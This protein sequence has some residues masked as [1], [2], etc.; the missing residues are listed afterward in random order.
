MA[1]P[2]EALHNALADKYELQEVLGEGGMGTVYLARDRKHDRPVA[3]KTIHP[4]RTTQEVRTRFEREIAITA[5]LQHPHILPLLDS[6]V[7]G[8]TLYY[9]MP[10][11]KGESLRDRLDRDSPLLLDEVLQI[12]RHVAAALDYAHQ[13][14]VVHRDIKPENILLTGDQAVVADFGISK[15]VGETAGTALTRSGALVGTPAYM[16]P[17]QFGGE[18]SGRSDIYALGAVLYEAL[19][20]RRWLLG[21]AVDEADWSGVDPEIRSGLARA[22]EPSPNARWEDASAFRKALE[23]G[24][25]Q[26]MILKIHRRRLWQALGIYGVGS[27]LVLQAVDTLAGALNLPDWAPPFALFLLIIGLPIVLATAF[28]QQGSRLEL[29]ETA[30]EEATEPGS[31]AA[32]AHHRL[33]TW[34]NAIAGGVVAF[35]LWGVVAAGWMLLGFG[36]ESRGQSAAADAPGID[37][38]SIAVL[39]FSNQSALEEDVFFVDGTHEDILTHLS[40]IDSLTVISRTSVMQYAGTTK[41]MREIAGELGVGTVLEGAVQRA[42]DRVQV[43]V[44][45]IDASTDRRLWAQIYDEELTAAN[46]FAIQSDIARKIAAALQATLAPDVKERIESRPTESL[47]A[48]DLYTRGRYL[49]NR[50]LTREDLES[51]ADLYRQAVA[52]DPAYALAHAGLAGSYAIL[53]DQGFLAAEEALPQARAA[54]ERALELDETL[55]EAHATLG[56]VLEAE[57]RAEA[58]RRVEA[59]R[60][61]KAERNAVARLRPQIEVALQAAELAGARRLELSSLLRGDS[62]MGAGLRDASEERHGEAFRKLELA[63]FAYGQAEREASRHF[64]ARLDSARASVDSLRG[65]ADRQASSFPEGEERRGLAEQAEATGDLPTALGHYERAARSY[66]GALP[67]VELPP[68]TALEPAPETPDPAELV[69][70]ALRSLEAAY[71][72][73]DLVAIQRIWVNLTADEVDRF[74]DFF[75][76]SREIDYEVDVVPSSI[77]ETEAGIEFDVVARFQFYPERGRDLERPAPFQLRF[78]L[79]DRSGRRV[80]IRR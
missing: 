8:E 62:L 37:R 41:P 10:Y 26:G 25:V 4:D 70:S 7:A 45:L 52:A 6:G 50:S 64:T 56:V 72:S 17:E 79:A 74:E 19:T 77:R 54:V 13:H 39:P 5:H 23:P 24:R 36:A 11:V 46:I 55:A 18:V 29:S 49:A 2:H 53:W 32:D 27:W 43:N 63:R 31:R 69:G 58:E 33:F 60:R 15:A 66:T 28:I 34:R 21:T 9:V 73:E 75:E 57:R 35:A 30:G 44:Q 76:N 48:Y 16:P 59:E 71:E 80:L 22:L 14:K 1:D 12:G 68:S 61:A 65:R 42:G 3:I 67:V 20:G 78:L 38:R 40:Q 47:E 51:A